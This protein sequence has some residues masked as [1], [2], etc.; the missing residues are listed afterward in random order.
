MHCLY[1]RIDNDDGSIYFVPVKEVK[2]NDTVIFDRQRLSACSKRIEQALL[3]FLVMKSENVDFNTAA[4][5]VARELGLQASTVKDKITRQLQLDTK[6][7]EIM[8]ND[9][10]AGKNTNFKRELMQK[11]VRVKADTDAIDFFCK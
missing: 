1:T 10:I 8:I 4:K 7:V 9:F 6:C 5:E 11:V 2:K 3:V